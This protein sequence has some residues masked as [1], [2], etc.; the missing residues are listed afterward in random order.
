MTNILRKKISTL[1][2][3]LLGAVWLLGIGA[4][5][6][7][8]YMNELSDLRMTL[9]AEIRE[10]GW[11][12]FLKNKGEDEDFSSEEW[13]YCVCRLRKDG[14][15]E[16]LSNHFPGL[17]EKE[18]LKYADKIFNGWKID[19]KKIVF[20][21]LTYVCKLSRTYGTCAILVSTEEAVHRAMPL[22]AMSAAAAVLG[23]CILAIVA[24]AFSGWL[25]RP[26][27]AS[28]RS[29][30]KFMSNASH[31]LKTP[32]SVIR[33][34]VE[35]LSEEIGENKHLQYIRM[36]TERMV[37][38]VSSMLTLVRLDAQYTEQRFEKFLLD[39]ALLN[40][41]YPME[42][43]AYEKKIRMEIHVEEGMWFVGDEEQLQSVMSILLDNAI[44][45]TPQGG[46]IEICADIRSRKF[47][48]TVLNTGEPIPEEQMERLFERFYR[49]D[50]ARENSSEH[51][52]LGLSIAKT[53]VEKHHGKIQAEST[54]GKNIF[55]VVLPLGKKL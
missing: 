42:S 14:T 39:E 6:W 44:S 52:G 40:V 25:V 20:R 3:V 35:L 33:T 9:R 18:I 27:E 29:E 10:I 17:S 47:H 8:N 32:L 21:K 54:G 49:R 7:M 38:L 16:I 50:E 19:D 45:Y 36:E 11:K 1:F 43:V 23:I 55:R 48:L 26:V 5:N 41:V 4:F 34:N 30:K 24:R 37:S 2:V 46:S 13:D 28:I 51:L 22:A 15:A 53:I 12:K 31:E